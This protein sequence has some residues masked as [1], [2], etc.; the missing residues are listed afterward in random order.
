MYGV[1]VVPTTATMSSSVVGFML[2]DGVT[3]AR[4]TGVQSGVASTAA[5]GYARKTIMTPRNTRSTIL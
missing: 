4:A 5:T 3:N 1:I 2:S